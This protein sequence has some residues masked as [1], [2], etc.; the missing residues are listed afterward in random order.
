MAKASDRE[1]QA[2]TERRPALIAASTL[3]KGS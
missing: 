1:S 2:D 3:G